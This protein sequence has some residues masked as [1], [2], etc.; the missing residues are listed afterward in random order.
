MHELDNSDD[1]AT[2]KAIR[3]ESLLT[4]KSTTIFR[5]GSTVSNHTAL[6][7]VIQADE[8]MTSVLHYF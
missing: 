5:D 2:L 1:N 4:F 3:L 7:T 8:V 6:T